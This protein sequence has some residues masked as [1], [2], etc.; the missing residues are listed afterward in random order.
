MHTVSPDDRGRLNLGKHVTRGETFAVE[1]VEGGFELVRLVKP[2]RTSGGGRR[3]DLG[4]LSRRQL[5]DLVK[6]AK[7]PKADLAGAIR[8]CR[9]EKAAQDES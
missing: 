1:P 4:Q 2:K 8:Q 3:L 5:L 7:M 9:R 6:L